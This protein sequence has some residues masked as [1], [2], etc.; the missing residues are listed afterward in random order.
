MN[1]TTK[2]FGAMSIFSIIIAIVYVC[3][4]LE[5]GDWAIRAL[6]FIVLAYL[7]EILEEVRK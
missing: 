4:G 5:I 3:V 1:D 2:F 7:S 6:I